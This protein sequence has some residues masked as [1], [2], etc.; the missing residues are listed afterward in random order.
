MGYALVP[1][2]RSGVIGR[3]PFGWDVA[4][5]TY[6]LLPG[7]LGG[8]DGALVWFETDVADDRVTK[9]A[10][11]AEE[12][13]SVTAR[14]VMG[15]RLTDRTIPAAGSFQSLVVDMLR[16]R[17]S[18]RWHNLLPS[19]K[20]ARYEIWLGPG[21]PGK[22]LFWSEAATRTKHSVTYT[23]NFNRSDGNLDG[24]TFSGGTATWSETGGTAYAITSNTATATNI[25]DNVEQVARASA[26]VDSDDMFAQFT[27]VTFTSNHSY[28]NMAPIARMHASLRNGYM[29]LVEN[30]TGTHTRILFT[31]GGEAVLGSSAGNSST[32]TVRVECDG[33]SIS[34][35]VGGSTI[36][37]PVT[38]SSETSGVGYR[39]A[40]MSAYSA[41][42]ATSDIAVDDFS[43]GDLVAGATVKTLAAMGV[44]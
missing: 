43:Y 25:P 36:I 44:G 42:G 5:N 35:L 19:H 18:Q 22:N 34:Y 2:V 26:E 29:A 16:D 33:S 8:E 31:Q 38:D 15:G 37:G 20:N 6:I 17:R 3:R 7:V 13:L 24:S 1:L 23:D 30:S 9:I 40:G 21:G 41:G 4:P 39:K 27:G 28:L 14:Q 12:R 32:S 10:D 11:G